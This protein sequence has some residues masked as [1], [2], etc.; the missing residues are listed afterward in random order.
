METF[1]ENFVDV[2]NFSLDYGLMS[3]KRMEQ[4]KTFS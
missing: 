1:C 4:E 3:V 2:L